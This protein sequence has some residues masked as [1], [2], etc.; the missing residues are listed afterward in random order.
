MRRRVFIKAIVGSSLAWPFA[1]RAQQ[2]GIP[3][4]GLLGIRT[5]EFDA[6]LLAEFIRGIRETGFVEGR[7]FKIEYRW[8]GGQFDRLPGLAEELVRQ[9]VAL[10]ITFGG[11][12][13]T[14]A[15]KAASTTIPI[16][17][18]T[19]DDPVLTGLVS[20]LNRPGGNITGGTFF[21]NELAAKQLDLLHRL[22]P[23]MSVLAMLTNPNEVGAES[24]I[25]DV[26]TAARSK[27]IQ[28]TVMR[29]GTER[30]IDEAFATFAEHHAGAVLIGSNPFYV[31]RANQ[32]IAL[33]THYALPTMFWRRELAQAGGL[34]SYGASPTEIHHQ[35]GTYAGRILKGEQPGD[36][37]VIQVTKI[38]FVINLKTAKALHLDIPPMLLA[39]ADEVME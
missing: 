35:I 26:E 27:G 32:I 8:A 3:V 11:T 23:T 17:F 38:D 4:I 1:V 14:R 34:M 13:A 20:N 10:I 6:P 15:A 37:P 28:L 36:L 16:V 29:A 25:N 24:E 12:A 5:A 22:L 9:K 2:A 30:D 7:D 21:Y 18:T 31:V 19:G 39:L 33:A